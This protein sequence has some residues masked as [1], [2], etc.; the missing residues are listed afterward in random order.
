[1]LARFA[2]MRTRAFTRS[3]G[4]GRQRQRRQNLWLG[5]RRLRA[6]TG[7]VRKDPAESIHP[8]RLDLALM[9]QRMVVHAKP[10][11]GELMHQMPV[12]RAE[13]PSVGRHAWAGGG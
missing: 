2:V 8:S 3:T 11:A 10:N 9:K 6:Q 13:R 4:P 7:L 1:M 5:R 12:R